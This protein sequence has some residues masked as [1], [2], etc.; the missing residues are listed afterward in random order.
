[1]SDDDHPA[2]TLLP[3]HTTPTWEM[4]LL[5][6]GVT[7]FALLQLAGMMDEAFLALL[8]RLDRDWAALSRLLFAYSKM[9]VLTLAIAFVL[10]LVLRGYWV[11]LVGM[12][13]IYPG[14]VRWDRLKTGPIQRR[15]IEHR[16]IR[17]ADRIETADNRASIVFALGVTFALILFGLVLVVV[18]GFTISSLLAWL[19]G[20]PWLLPNGVFLLLALIALPYAIAYGF[21]RRFGARVAPAGRTSRV[22]AAIYR[23]YAQLGYGSDSNPI[24]TL[25]KS[26]VGERKVFVATF[27]SI[28]FVAAIVMGQLTLQMNP[29][30][31]GDY[32]L[33][34]DAEA[35]A[36]DSVIHQHYRDKAGPINALLPTI[37]SMFPAG[38][39]L[40]LFVPFDPKLHPALLADSCPD[41]WNA[42]AT[43]SQRA[44]LLECLAQW[45]QLTLDGQPLE[46]PALRYYSDPRTAQQGAIAIVP[47]RNLAPG[48]H[49]LSLRR[50]QRKAPE[51]HDKAADRYRI[52]FW[53]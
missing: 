5:L 18:V 20:W 36:T 31:I 41:I 39:Y 27:V 34:P 46:T 23:F 44:P 16:G 43:Q 17:I 33:W 3:R 30:A 50:A 19:F 38:D 25:L 45:Q 53:K 35:G 37:D 7:V 29:V 26:H 48:E 14:G 10:H 12:N 42:A 40:S 2:G 9:S 24:M 4:E 52:A 51:D 49:L 13:S 22:V 11:A 6:S 15:V 21:D 47:I 1:M 8:P 32:T 28:L